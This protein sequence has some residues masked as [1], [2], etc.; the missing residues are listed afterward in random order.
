MAHLYII[1]HTTNDDASRFIGVNDVVAGLRFGDGDGGKEIALFSKQLLVTCRLNGV[2]SIKPGLGQG[3]IIGTVDH[4]KPT[5]AGTCHTTDIARCCG[6][7]AS[8]GLLEQFGRVNPLTDRLL[9]R[10]QF[11]I[12]R[13][14][15][16]SRCGGLRFG[17]NRLLACR[18]TARLG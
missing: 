13:L 7:V 18:L 6:C 14:S 3:G 4:H 17:S 9:Q 16:S 5:R 10:G 15:I 1:H 12:G 11:R 8:G 2:I